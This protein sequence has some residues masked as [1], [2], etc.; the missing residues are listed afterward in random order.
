MEIDVERKP[1]DELKDL[2]FSVR[3]A[4]CPQN[5]KDIEYC[6]TLQ[7]RGIC[8]NLEGIVIVP[9]GFIQIKCKVSPSLLSWY[10]N[11]V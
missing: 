10:Q 6:C 1:L 4:G 9:D 2:P 3:Y 11:I 5:T 7:T 8:I